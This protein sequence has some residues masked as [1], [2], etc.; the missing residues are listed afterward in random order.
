VL[1]VAR[2]EP[3]E[4]LVEWGDKFEQIM[5][6]EGKLVAKPDVLAANTVTP[7]TDPNRTQP[8]ER[9]VGRLR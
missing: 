9:Y 5:F 6:G 1:R 7:L 8:T 3:H 2:S 4:D